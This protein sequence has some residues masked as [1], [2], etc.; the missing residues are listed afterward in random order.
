MKKLIFSGILTSIFAISSV[1]FADPEPGSTV[2]G[3]GENDTTLTTKKYVDDGLIYVYDKVKTAKN[4]ADT[5]KNTADAAMEAIGD[6]N[7]GL[8]KRVKDLEDNPATYTAG[9]GIDITNG[10][11][12]VD[13]LDDTK[14]NNNKDKVYVYRNGALEELPVTNN[15][16]ASVLGEED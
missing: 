5:A 11:V 9:T 10:T 8:T 4:T 6:N 1:A 2:L 16:S 14:T 12:S 3:V 13:G 7:S 15:W